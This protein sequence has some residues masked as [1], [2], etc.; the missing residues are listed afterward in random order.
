MPA[1]RQPAHDVRVGWG[2]TGAAALATPVTVVVD[3]LSFTTTLT[4]ALDRG[5]TVYPFRWKDQ[6]ATAYAAAR[7]AVLAQ[8]RST[9]SAVSLSPLSVRAAAGVERLVLPSPNGSAIAFGLAGAGSTVVGASLRNRAAVAR[10]LV[11]QP[12]PIG[13]VPAGERWPDGSLRPAVEDLWGAG[14]VVAALVDLGVG[15][16]SPEAR[17]AEH[18]FRAVAPRLAEELHACVSGQELTG[19]GFAGD[20]DVAAELDRSDVVPVLESDAFVDVR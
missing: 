11:E 10:W 2:P 1:Y 20:V 19:I 8:G 9:G 18:A 17:V 7:D 6:R 3:V 4:V 16:L 5:M 13:I 14:A 12:R 15:G